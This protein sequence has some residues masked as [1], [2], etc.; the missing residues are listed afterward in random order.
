MAIT[1][2]ND[3]VNHRALLAALNTIRAEVEGRQ[4]DVNNLAAW[5]GEMAARM[6]GI[7]EELKALEVDTF[8]IGNIHM[9]GDLVT[10]QKTIADAYKNA[11][12]TTVTQAGVAARTAHRNHG[13][14]QEAVDNA[15]VPMA[16]NTFYS[17]E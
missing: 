9:L 7:A 5:S 6:T 13:R 17:A 14:V 15:D 16:R 2:I 3:V 4:E 1:K 11:T 10:A 12:D 8:T